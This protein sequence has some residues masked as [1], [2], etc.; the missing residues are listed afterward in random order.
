MAS[1]LETLDLRVRFF[2]CHAHPG[3]RFRADPGPL[4]PGPLFDGAEELSGFLL[5]VH[6]D[7]RG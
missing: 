2:E 7:V 6:V 3:L 5:L 4:F 1:A